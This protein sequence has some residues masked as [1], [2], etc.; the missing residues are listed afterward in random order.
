MKTALITGAT[1]GIGWAT[2]ERLAKEGNFRLVLCGRR[3]DRLREL[4]EKLTALCPVKTLNFDVRDHVA[5]AAALDSLEGDFSEIDVLINNAGNA[6]GMEPIQ[7]GS[8]DDWDLMID[9]NVKALLAITRKVAPE[10]I[11]RHRG[12]IINIG[13][14]AGKETYPNGAVYCASKAAVD[15]LTQGMRMDLHMHNIRVSAIHPGMVETEFSWVRFKGDQARADKVYEGVK[16]LTGADIAEMIAF[17]I[18]QPDHVV[19]ADM[20]VF[21]TAQASATRVHRG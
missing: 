6:H 8:M 5:M 2:A 7:E 17:I 14:I 20:V 18:L 11:K 9:I 16:P 3:K 4:S 15:A 1:S 10:M 13:S 12:Q 21:P 19:V